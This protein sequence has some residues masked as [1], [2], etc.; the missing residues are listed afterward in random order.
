IVTLP[1]RKIRWYE[2]I[3]RLK[4]EYGEV[5]LPDDVA[6]IAEEGGLSARLDRELI[7]RA[8]QV[9]RRLQ[10][11]NR[12]VG[13][14]IDLAPASLADGSHFGEIVDFLGANQA[15]AQSLTFEVPQ[16]AYRSF[17]AIEFEGM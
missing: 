5:M 3:A 9:V 17:G 13:L 1:Q 4:T 8:V 12:E 2:I 14:L 15:L 10:A 11:R 16:A 6:P 7:L